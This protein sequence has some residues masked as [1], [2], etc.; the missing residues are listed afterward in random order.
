MMFD[1]RV[2]VTRESPSL[3]SGDT[4]RIQGIKRNPDGALAVAES[5]GSFPR[6]SFNGTNDQLFLRVI[7]GTGTNGAGAVVGAAGA[8]LDRSPPSINGSF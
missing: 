2:E 6:S 1:E 3:A 7:T 8:A 4:H 5:F